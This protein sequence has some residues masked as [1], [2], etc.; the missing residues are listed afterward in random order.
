MAHLRL[1]VLGGLQLR[2]AEG[3]SRV[4]LPTRKSGALLAYLALAPGALRSREQLA[5]TLW[6]RSAEDQARASLRQ[7]L[8]TL[9]R[10]LR[11]DS[12]PIIRTDGDSVSLD[13][14]AVDVDA[15]QF[16]RLAAQQSPESLEAGVGLYQGALLEGFSLR[17]EGFDEWMAA[18]R[19]RFHAL[20]LQTL[21]ALVDQYARTDD[22]DRGIRTV[23]RLLVLDPLQEWAHCTLMRLLWRSGRREAALRQYQ[24]CVQILKRELTIEPAEETQRLASEIA[25]QRSAAPSVEPRRDA[26]PGAAP[27]SDPRS[28]GP[29]PVLPAERKQLTVL[30]ARIHDA[31]DGADPEVALERTDPALKTMAEEVRRLEGT[32]SHIGGDRL[33]ALFGAPVAHEDHAVRACYAALSIRDAISSLAGRPLDLRIGIHSG[34]AVVRTI[35]DESSRHYEAVGPMAQLANGIDVALRPGEIG[36]TT[37]TARRAEGFVEVSPLGAKSLETVR[38]QV[39]L[40][41]L[42]ARTPL[43]LRWEAR[44]ARELTQF[45]G[46]DA[47]IDRLSALLA[48]A[49]PGA[50]QAALIVGEPGI[51]KS[52]LAHEFVHSRRVDGWTVLQSGT[53]SHDT[54]ATYFPIAGLLRLWFDIGVRD[55]QA[56]ALAKLHGG[57]EGIDRALMPALPPLCALLDL[58]VDD[59]QWPML[60]PAQKRLRTLHAVHALVMRKAEVSPLVLVVED[61]HW[62]DAGSQAV[63][64]HLVGGLAASRVLLLFTCRPEY[65]HEW[66]GKSNFSRLRLDP[67]PTANADRLL[68]TLLGED[69][70]LAALRRTLVTQTGGT[71]LFLEES[72]RALVETGALVGQV[73]AYRTVGTDQDLQIP[74]TVQ[75]VLAARID[76]LPPAAKNLLQTAAVIGKD[77]P[78]GLLQPIAGMAEE[79]LHDTLAELQ[80]A[81]FLYQTRLLPESE[82]TF[83]HALTHQVAYESVLRDRRRTVHIQLVELIETLYADRLDEQVERL[84]HHAFG[85]ELWEKAILYLH[86]SAVRAMQRSAHQQA[87]QYLKRGL[88]IINS[89]P[90]SEQRQRGELEYQKAMGVTMMAA[91]GWAAKEVLDA[92]TRARQ[93]CEELRDERELFIALRGQGQYRMIRGESAIARGLGERCVELASRSKDVG[94]QIETHHL[95]WTNSFFM[96]DYRSVDLHCRKCIGL[97]DRHRDHELTYVYS[98]HDPGVCSRA[99]LALTQCLRGFPDQALGGCQEALEL[100]EQFKHPLTTSLAHWAYSYVHL[101]RREPQAARR[102]AELEIAVC[103]E[104]LLPLMRSHGIFQLGWALAELG[105]LESGIARMREG[106]AG[107]SATGAEMGSPYFSALLAEALGKAGMPDEGLEE[108]ERALAAA[109]RNGARFQISEMLRVKGDLL[110]MRSKTGVSEAEA[111]FRDSLAAGAQQGARLPMLRSAVSLARLLLGRGARAE[112]RALLQPASLAVTEGRDIPVHREAASLL[113]AL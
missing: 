107:N 43:R 70:S 47:E 105:E 95:F 17:E 8:S 94:V 100:A 64:D 67:L 51:G 6:G 68:Q 108:I 48:L 24:E 99:F 78:L 111:C 42:N 34:N 89:L 98:G 46:R 73:G 113:A 109:D 57:V 30:C 33:T 12:V 91:R 112:A 88:G 59:A 31:I 16:E 72:V 69:Q 45:V 18:E 5:G 96:G 7:M 83:K 23:E 21:S 79:S 60:S 110:L 63:L 77:V 58:P 39:E 80:G 101:F 10:T 37:E 66:F 50:G 1:T 54:G 9:R 81:E 75:A 40:F 62:L 15:L 97:Y 74:S 20:A 76:R 71:P 61:L 44:S 38:K 25:H 3:D 29:L 56:E 84:A 32:I 36:V 93:L 26:P 11:T 102:W 106:L 92:Y 4:H 65:R 22:F 103:D 28:T 2:L 14:T 86:R 27:T 19:R 85:G 35:G 82:Y 52:R 41:A 49:G 87:I 90:D 13:T 53:S 55:R 104:Y